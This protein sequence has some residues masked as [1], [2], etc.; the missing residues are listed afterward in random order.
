LPWSTKYGRTVRLIVSVMSGSAA[1]MISR[2][3]A[4]ISCCQSGSD[5][6]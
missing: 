5:A 4:Q 6:M 1:W 3:C 2:N